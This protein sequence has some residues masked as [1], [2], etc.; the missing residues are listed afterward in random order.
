M[1]DGIYFSIYKVNDGGWE[2]TRT[3]YDEYYY[4]R[5]SGAKTRKEQSIL[6]IV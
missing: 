2:A 1:A 5:N 3:P 4:S 6:L